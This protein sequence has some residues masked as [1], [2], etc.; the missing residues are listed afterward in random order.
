MKVNIHSIEIILF[1]DI[2][3]FPLVSIEFICFIF[4]FK[5]VGGNIESTINCTKNPCIC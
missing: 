3:E 2:V 5:L 4:I 1:V